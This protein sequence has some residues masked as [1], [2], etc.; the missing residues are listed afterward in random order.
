MSKGQKCNEYLQGIKLPLVI[1]ETALFLSIE[2]FAILKI[3][4]WL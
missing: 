2:P 3:T 4:V 1:H